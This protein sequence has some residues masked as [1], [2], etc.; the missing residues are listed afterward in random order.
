MEMS[1]K[2]HEVSLVGWIRVCGGK[3]L[4]KSFVLS[5]HFFL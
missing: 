1:P 2:F 3:D 5:M 4:W